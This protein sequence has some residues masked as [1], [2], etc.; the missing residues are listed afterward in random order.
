MRVTIK[1]ENLIVLI[2]RVKRQSEFVT[3]K[4]VARLLGLSTKSAGRALAELER[5]GYLRRISKKAYKIL[6]VPETLN[7]GQ[8]YEYK[9]TFRANTSTNCQKNA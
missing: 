1:P 4:E 8:S 3:V 9:S 7:G 5:K 6:A 2:T